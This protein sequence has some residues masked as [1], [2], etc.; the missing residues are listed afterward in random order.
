MKIIIFGA[1]GMVGA[2]VLREVLNAPQIESV[3]SIGRNPCEVR[4]SNGQ[5]LSDRAI[6]DV[7]VSKWWPTIIQIIDITQ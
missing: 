4:H 6:R 5:T 7:R 3:L 1:S 2:G